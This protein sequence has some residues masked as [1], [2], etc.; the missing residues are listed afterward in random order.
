MAEVATAPGTWVEAAAG[1]DDEA[2][3]GTTDATAPGTWVEAAAGADD[4]A[5]TGTTDA[6]APGATWAG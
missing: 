5:A 6:T 2:A 3:A 4:E 1:A